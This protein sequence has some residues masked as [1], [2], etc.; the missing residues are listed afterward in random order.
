[1][2]IPVHEYLFQVSPK[3]SYSN[4]YLVIK[5]NW[6]V[7]MS[8]TNERHHVTSCTNLSLSQCNVVPKI[9]KLCPCKW[10][11][12]WIHDTLICR[13][14]EH[15]AFT[16]CLLCHIETVFSRIPIL[17]CHEKVVQYRTSHATSP[18]TFIPVNLWAYET[19]L[20]RQ[21]CKQYILKWD[22]VGSILKQTKGKHR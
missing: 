9:S 15:W 12:D 8:F 1:M 6:T 16:V 21:K 3:E 11:Y 5:S 18:H 4:D 17:W 19:L 14:H 2:Y 13:M 7:N 20:I 22:A 10:E